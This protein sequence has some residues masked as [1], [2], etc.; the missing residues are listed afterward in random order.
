MRGNVVEEEHGVGTDGEQRNANRDVAQDG[1]PCGVP[2]YHG[3][4]SYAM[5]TSLG[6]QVG[7]SLLITV[8]N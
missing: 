4:A 3:N 2:E 7:K 1:V 5:D 8:H 6:D